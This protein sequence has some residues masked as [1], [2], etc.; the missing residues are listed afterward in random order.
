L[1]QEL[2]ALA[3]AQVDGTL[4]GQIASRKRSLLAELEHRESLRRQVQARLGYA[5]DADGSRAS[6]ADAGC[7]DAWEACLSAT[8]ETARLN[9]LAGQLLGMRLAHNQQ[10]LDIIHRVAEKTLYGPSGRSGPQ[11]GRLNASA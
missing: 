2:D 7:L 4:L 11:P 9:A 1:E 3:A 10:M 5:P 6:A 8:R